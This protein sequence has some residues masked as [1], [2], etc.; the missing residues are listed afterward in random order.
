MDKRMKRHP[1]VLSR[2]EA[3]ATRWA[4]A[5]QDSEGLEQVLKEISEH[6]GHQRRII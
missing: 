2:Q 6:E 5:E 4:T 3:P 1:S